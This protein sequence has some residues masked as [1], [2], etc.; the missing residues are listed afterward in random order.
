M[1]KQTHDIL[2]FINNA[3][4]FIQDGER[5]YAGQTPMSSYDVRTSFTSEELHVL[6]GRL[7]AVMPELIRLATAQLGNLANPN[8]KYMMASHV[9]KTLEYWGGIAELVNIKGERVPY[10]E[11]TCIFQ[12]MP[13]DFDEGVW[14]GVFDY[15]L[16]YCK[17]SAGRDIEYVIGTPLNAHEV[18]R[19]WLNETYPNWEAR[20]LAAESLG[21]EDTALMRLVFNTDTPASSPQALSGLTL[22][23]DN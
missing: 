9:Q 13:S 12:E 8:Y 11:F 14:M 15:H 18:S 17:D 2:N 7:A 5:W 16:Q 23:M 22:T 10:K 21:Y 20:L 6:D 1:H 4:I 19:A 3:G